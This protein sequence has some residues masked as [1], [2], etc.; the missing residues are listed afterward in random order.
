MPCGPPNADT[1]VPVETEPAEAIESI[2]F[3]LGGAAGHV[4]VVD[5]DDEDPIVMAGEQPVE[6]GGTGVPDVEQPGRRW[7]DPYPDEIGVHCAARTT[8]FPSTPIPSTST[9]MT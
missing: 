9:S 7:G 5:A 1:L 3:E 4:G 8:G 6:Q 2:L